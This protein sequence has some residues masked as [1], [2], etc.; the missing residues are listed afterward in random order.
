MYADPRHIRQHVVKVR[1]NA[2]ELHL[3]GALAEYNRSQPA[4]FAREMLLR[5]IREME[6]SD[7]QRQRLAWPAMAEITL[8]LTDAEFEALK[9]A[10]PGVSPDDAAAM[11]VRAEM[12]RRYRADAKAG[13]V[14]NFSAR[15]SAGGWDP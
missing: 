15:K 4:T 6:E 11:M 8:H 3:L 5:A 1:L 9:R 13:R 12:D 10:F 14:R 7:S 2:D